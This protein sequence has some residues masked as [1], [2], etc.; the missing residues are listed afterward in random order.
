MCSVKGRGRQRYTGAASCMAGP[1]GII[2]SCTS[3]LGLR[4]QSRFHLED[5]VCLGGSCPL[6]L[7][8]HQCSQR[9]AIS[10]Q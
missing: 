7:H 4:T 8:M 9:G 2:T 10:P 1:I 5:L 3:V 6:W